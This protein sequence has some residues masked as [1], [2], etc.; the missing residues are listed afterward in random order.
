[1]LVLVTK[2]GE[3]PVQAPIVEQRTWE[4]MF[5]RVQNKALYSLF[6]SDESAS[7][8]LER[9]NPANPAP[10]VLYEF[11][12]GACLDDFALEYVSFRHVSFRAEKLGVPTIP[13]VYDLVLAEAFTNPEVTGVLQDIATRSALVLPHP[14]KS[15]A[16]TNSLPLCEKIKTRQGLLRVSNPSVPV[17]QWMWDDVHA[18]GK[19]PFLYAKGVPKRAVARLRYVPTV[20]EERMGLEEKTEL[21]AYEV[22]RDPTGF[23]VKPMNPGQLNVLSLVY[24]MRRAHHEYGGHETSL[25]LALH[26]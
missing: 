25:E 14:L 4:D 19:S 26:S 23:L 7:K 22:L 1:M 21:I 20:R 9:W 15:Q 12:Q 13:L 24:A 2:C 17:R 10:V 5:Q 16:L 6:L 18:A 8:A 11:S 3:R